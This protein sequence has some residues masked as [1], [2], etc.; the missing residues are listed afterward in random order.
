MINVLALALLVIIKKEGAQWNALLTFGVILSFA[1]AYLFAWADFS[2]KAK[3]GKNKWWIIFI[4]GMVVITGI[5]NFLIK[6]FADQLGKREFL[7]FWYSGIC[8]GSLG[9]ALLPKNRKEP[10]GH[11]KSILL[12]LVLSWTVIGSMATFYWAF[13]LTLGSRVLPLRAVGTT[14][15]PVIIGYLGF[16]EREN[17]TWKEISA[18]FAGGIAAFLIIFS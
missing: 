17:L 14:F 8:L 16:G 10:L 2:K 12:L 13:Q 4:V 6:D 18:F 9:I 3:G 15:L 5:S 1:S 11:S 7:A